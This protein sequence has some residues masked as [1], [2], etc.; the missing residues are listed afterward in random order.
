MLRSLLILLCICCSAL[1]GR[2]QDLSPEAYL[3]YPI[4]ENF[5][6]HHRIVSYV[7]WLAE[8]E[9][10]RVKLIPYGT[11]NEGRPLMVVA[12]GSPEN[13]GRLD[14]IREDHLKSIGLREGNPEQKT[15]LIAWLSY[16]VHGDE[17][18]SS[19]AAMQVISELLD[20]DHPVF[21][22]ILTNTVVLVDP[23]LNPDG[24][25]RY[26]NWYRQVKG[27]YPDP[28]AFS[29]EHRQ[30]WPGGRY[31]H[32]L[33]DLNRDWAWQ[34]HEE[35]RARLRLYQEWMPHLHADFHEMGPGNSYY[36]PPAAR[37][38]HADITPW[39]R[40]FNEL[41]GEHNRQ[42]FDRHHWLYFTKRDFDL[43]YPS[44]GDTWPTYNG[45]I[46]MTYE[47]AGGGQA[48]LALA[49]EEEGDTLTL[50]Q[51]VAH[52]VAASQATLEALAANSTRTRKEF[53]DFFAKAATDPVGKFKTYAVKTAGFEGN[54]K[55]LCELL[56]RQG[57]VYG[58]AGKQLSVKGT[59]LALMKEEPLQLE[60][61]DLLISAY[62][63]K[64]GLLKIVMEPRPELEDSLTYDITSWGLGLVYGVHSYGITGKLVPEKL[65]A[66]AG[67]QQMTG[68][69]PY[70]YLVRWESFREMQ[71]LSEL[72][73][74]KVKVRTTNLPFET[75]DGA[76][77]AG[78]LI[79]TRAGNEALG[80]QLDR[81]LYDISQKHQVTLHPVTTGM[82]KTGPDFGADEVTVIRPPRV[83]TVAGPGVSPL[84]FGEVWH[85]FDQQ[86]GYPLTI[87]DVNR[88]Q[89]FSWDHTDVL[90]LPSGQY[91]DHLNEQTLKQLQDW[92]TKGGR[93]IVM[94]GALRHFL[95]RPGFELALKPLEQKRKEE[96]LKLFGDR[97][98]E[99]VRYE[100]PG[101]IY[102]V[103]LDT[104]HPLAFGYA[105]KTYYASVRQTYQYAYL[106]NAWNVG[107]LGEDAYRG[108]FVGDRAQPRLQ[109]TL[110]LGCQE[111]GRGSVVYMAD[112][113]LFRGFWY[114][115][116]LLFGNAV[117]RGR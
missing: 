44:Y 102:E 55:A 36:F 39:Q 45:A 17:A 38:F 101:S 33:A 100:T 85:Y 34:V 26:V 19:E 82:V 2:G 64:S 103:T 21:P 90:I 18:V 54:V 107:V 59:D 9:P 63:P 109:H 42:H 48:G 98:R 15:P 113:P 10:S 61:E 114:N 60:K 88:L 16:N 7:Q 40:E 80:D 70:A 73:T 69:K 20:P 53:K 86:I 111:V 104:T 35:S 96:P 11:S 95:E 108:G 12:I 50:A 99:A 89:N 23:C 106:K 91:G 68:Q 75:G 112:D 27:K 8:K 72:L 29:R 41:L 4:G 5:T 28:A 56:D 1:S 67:V 57:I 14:R 83:V 94:E 49:R 51:R 84:A 93:L 74:K 66:A 13:I 71:L 110:I 37:P 30:P 117:F 47:Q 32:Y 22:E 116:R 65:P 31:N 81:M 43:F 76:F 92:L 58:V 79:I 105:G 52:H 87:V 3:G 97:Q 62:Q 25:E 77:P 46:G 6:Y 78:T 24:H 115:G